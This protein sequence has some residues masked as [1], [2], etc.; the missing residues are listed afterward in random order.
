M[1]H[2]SL[3]HIGAYIH[4]ATLA[5]APHAQAT[6]TREGPALP[7][8][9]FRSGVLTVFTG[10]ASGTPTA[11]AVAYTLQSRTDDTGT[12]VD[13]K[14]PDGGDHTVSLSAADSVAELDVS[15]LHLEDEHTQLRVVE[16]TTLAGGSTPTV[17]TGATLV[18]G[19]SS[20]RPV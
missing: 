20:R 5:L 8:G 12:W 4:T 15:F 6:G 16:T 2:P 10:T 11:V 19:G 17:I 9:D 7:V 13:V 3:V 14:T 18:R 1:A